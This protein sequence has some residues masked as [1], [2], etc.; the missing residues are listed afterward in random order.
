MTG[1][2]L[3]RAPTGLHRVTVTNSKALLPL[4]LLGV[5]MGA[6]DLAIVGPALP[7]IKHDLG[8]DDRQ[9]SVLFN[10]YVLLQMIGTPLLAKFGDRMGARLAYVAGIAFFAVGSLV[11]VAAY[12]PVVLYVGRALQGFGG[13]GILPVAAAVIATNVAPEKRGPALGMLGAVFGLAFIL[14]PVL[15]GLLLP[16]GWHWL[17]LINIPISAVLAVGAFR[18]L[19][20]VSHPERLPLDVL[21]IGTLSV[22]LA[23]LVYGLSVLDVQDLAASLSRWPVL[24]AGALV[25][26]LVPVFWMVEKRAAD[27]IVRPGLVASRPIALSAAISAGAGLIQSGNGFFPILAVTAIGVSAS[28]AAWML[29]P[30]VVMATVAAPLVGKLLNAHAA[31]SLILVGMLL[32]IASLLLYGLVPMSIPVFIIA[33]MIGGA[34][35][36][37]VMGAPLRMVVLNHSTERE[38]GAAQGLLSNFTSVGRLAGAALVGAIAGS[39]GGGARGYQAAY[40]ALG[41]FAIALSLLALMLKGGRPAGGDPRRG[42]AGDAQPA[43]GARNIR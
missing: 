38:R 34:G 5:L 7:A 32:V 24:L 23:A 29:L 36:A 42:G 22:L 37:S 41:V 19:P 43:G 21:G 31:R 4:L 40:V 25:V 9:A 12:S 2:T 35:M 11:V 1:G 6:M 20:V 39:F 13:G 3:R 14:G 17:F 18:L 8:M 26:I 27:P 16:L 10:A 33:G 30:G 28:T 15:G